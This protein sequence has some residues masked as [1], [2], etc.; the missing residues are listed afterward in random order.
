MNKARGFTLVELMVTLVVVAILMAIAIPSYRQ[1]VIKGNRRAAQAVMMEL[2][3]RQEQ[4]FV[5]NRVYATK[6]ELDYNLPPEV[7]AN[8]EYDFAIDGGPPPSV[9]VNFTAEGGQLGDG[10]L[11]ASTLGTKTPADKW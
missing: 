7:D 5:A 3:S 1:S 9:T 11:S 2:I 8:Y 4:Y 6:A 10:D